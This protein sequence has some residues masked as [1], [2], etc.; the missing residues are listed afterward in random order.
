MLTRPR[1]LVR[2]LFADISE[3]LPEAV[4][5]RDIAELLV[6]RATGGLA[7]SIPGRT[8]GPLAR[9]LGFAQL[10]FEVRHPRLHRSVARRRRGPRART[11]GAQLTYSIVGLLDFLE[12]TRR[13]RRA[14]VVVRMVK[15][16]QPPVGVVQ[17]LRRGAARDAE[18]QVRITAHE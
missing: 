12:P 11:R 2:N 10:A 5:G 16:H 3:D 8:T 14:G 15:L 4:V 6:G 7:N 18:H 9:R 13:L 17:R 1:E